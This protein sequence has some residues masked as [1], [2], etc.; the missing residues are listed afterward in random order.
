[1][2]LWLAAI[3]WF[4]LALLLI[5]AGVLVLKGC[6]IRIGD[7]TILN[8]CPEPPPAAP[9]RPADLD[10]EQQRSSDL[11]QRL[12]ELRL[13]MIAV[14]DCP[15]PEPP[16]PPPPE[17]KPE[18][19]P[20]PQP[21]PQPEPQ[22]EPAPQPTPKP[23]GEAACREV[24][25]D[26]RNIDIYLLLDV[27]GSFEDDL[28]SIRAALQDL[29]GRKASGRLKGRIRLGL[30]TF[31]DIPTLRAPNIYPYRHHQNLTEDLTR[32]LAA[33][34]IGIVYGN[35]DEPESQLYAMRETAQRAGSIGFA[36]DAA[37]F[38]VV[39]TDAGYHQ[40]GEHPSVA[41]VKAAFDSANLTPIFLVTNNE[42]GTYRNLVAKLGRGAVVPLS[43]D[44]SNLLQALSSG[45]Q[46][47]CGEGLTN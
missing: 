31:V 45:I 7:T 42:V 47:I 39:V 37:R 3:F 32:V 4:L 40:G 10:Q 2:R 13:R 33:A 20:Q 1:M 24:P 28:P 6:G 25:P 17:P 46:T 9:E 15:P 44:S 38:V 27:S 5:A 11:Q 19:A 30:G 36:D 41:Q 12:H 23:T 21:Q 8:F 34:R 14:K 18:P 22:P 43:S 35:H 29:V 26:E 16:P